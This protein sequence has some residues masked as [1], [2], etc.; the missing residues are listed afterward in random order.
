MT[1]H[2]V[3]HGSSFKRHHKQELCQEKPSSCVKFVIL[4]RYER[5]R[6]K[7]FSKSN[8]KTPWRRNIAMFQWVSRAKSSTMY[9]IELPASVVL[10][11]H[12]YRSS[13]VALFPSRFVDFI[14][15]C[16]IEPLQE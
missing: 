15:C 9:T 4:D 2:L 14:L 7:D 5:Y 6:A 3:S 10:H 16:I 1:S 11:K 13:D 8:R 12:E